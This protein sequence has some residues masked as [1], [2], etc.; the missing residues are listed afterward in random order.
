MTTNTENQAGSLDGLKWGLA[1]LLVAAAVVGNHYYA[2]V[3][4]LIRVIAVVAAIAIALGVSSQTAKGKA[5][6][7]FAKESRTEVRK[8]VWP[9]R[10]ESTQTTLIVLAA[11]AFM[12]LVLW[13]LDTILVKL[14]ALITGVGI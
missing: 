4:V 5:A 9:T 12:A 2:D 11:T 7:V 14:V 1:G 10:Q 13:L 6:F 3:S 8:V